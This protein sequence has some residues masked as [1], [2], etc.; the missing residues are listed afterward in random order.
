MRAVYIFALAVA[1]LISVSGN[2]DVEEFWRLEQLEK[3]KPCWNGEV[4][5]DHYYK[6]V[7]LDNVKAASSKIRVWFASERH[8][9][10]NQW[11]CN[12]LSDGNHPCYA[13]QEHLMGKCCSWRQRSCMLSQMSDWV[14]FS[15]LREPLAKF[16]SGVHEAKLQDPKLHLLSGDELLDMQLSQTGFV[17][18]HFQPSWCRLKV[19]AANGMVKLNCIAKLETIVEDIEAFLPTLKN[20]L[21][22]KFFL[23]LAAEFDQGPVVR[24]SADVGG[25]STTNKLSPESRMKFL[26]SSLY[27]GEYLRFA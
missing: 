17:N 19:R 18:E 12:N 20:A 22:H 15:V 27:G 4:I 8:I 7:Y 24:S 25:N 6:V 21:H 14:W 1:W 9:E 3:D 10:W 11:Q 26:N 23:S 13:C 2:K 16:D 5:F